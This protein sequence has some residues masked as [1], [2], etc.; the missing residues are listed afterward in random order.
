[1]SVKETPSI[2]REIQIKTPRIYHFICIRGGFPGGTSGEEP[3][4]QCRRQESH[5]FDP[6]VGKSPWRRA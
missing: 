5:G 3:P 4:C 6:W 1:M 2:I